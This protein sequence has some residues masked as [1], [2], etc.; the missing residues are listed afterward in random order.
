MSDRRGAG[1]HIPPGVY[2]ELV[3]SL[4]A[5]LTP[6]T[7]MGILFIVV[8][9]LAARTTP[10]P[11]LEG[12]A[13]LGSV[14]SLLR[15]AVIVGCAPLIRDPEA[16]TARVRG[17]ELLFGT[18]YLCFAALLGLLAW[19][20][21]QLSQ[22]DVHMVV[23]PLVVGYA[24]GVA[25]G[26]S[27]RPW[28]CVPAVLLAVVPLI[29]ASVLKTH[30]NYLVL[31][32]VLAALLVGGIG[33]MLARYRSESEKITM[34]E[35]LGSMARQDYLTGLANRLG[36]EEA[37]SRCAAAHGVE[38]VAVHCL[39]LDRFKQVND[40]LGHP[41]GDLLLKLAAERLRAQTRK[42]DVAARLG[43]DEFVVVQ[44]GLTHPNQAE[45]MARRIVRAL[46]E[47]Y[48]VD[49]QRAVVGASVGYAIGGEC[50]GDLPRL[51]ECADRALYGIKRKGGGAAAHRP[52]ADENP[53]LRLAG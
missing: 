44:T 50:G 12:V 25:A 16:D 28:I 36:L 53:G 24:A 39:D 7:I 6:T 23:A 21:F 9:S 19:R 31:G 4:F 32:F 48:L 40:D 51:L 14:V 1:P 5:T 3:R 46:G 30:G 22:P 52:E 47:P 33:S 35:L 27:L 26:M 20:T 10:D 37:F 34:R 29:A 41:A 2:V 45:M 13:V 18:V 49:G 17:I 15:V 8:A 38:A 43:G 11:M 42:G